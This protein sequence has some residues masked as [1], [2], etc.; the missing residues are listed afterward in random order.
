M[1][2]PME[3]GL[4]NGPDAHRPMA[5]GLGGRS[6]KPMQGV[7]HLRHHREHLPDLPHDVVP[8]FVKPFGS[9]PR[10]RWAVA[11]AAAFRSFVHHLH[12]VL[13]KG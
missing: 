12:L 4:Q 5:Q 3:T 6:Q 11:A 2:G 7:L 8:H 10:M 1:Q 9:A 13:Q